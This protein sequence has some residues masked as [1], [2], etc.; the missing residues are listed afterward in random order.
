MNDLQST[1]KEELNYSMQLKK[2]VQ[3]LSETVKK[4]SASNKDE[5]MDEMS[6]MRD[7]IRAL[8]EGKRLCKSV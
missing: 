8:E 3:M 2:E 5:E 7:Q 4:S 1:L 6:M